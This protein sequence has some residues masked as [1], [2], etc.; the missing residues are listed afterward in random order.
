MYKILIVEDDLVIARTMYKHLESWGY[1]V[2]CVSDFSNVMQQFV[3]LR[4]S[5]FC[6]TYRCPFTM[7]FTGAMR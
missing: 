7:V 2:Q 1:E 6:W 5:W 4:L 3:A